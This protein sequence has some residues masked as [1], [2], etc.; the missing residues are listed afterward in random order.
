[1][2]CFFHVVSSKPFTGK[3]SEIECQA[4]VSCFS[5]PIKIDLQ[6]N[7]NNNNNKKQKQKKNP[8]NKKARQLNINHPKLV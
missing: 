3:P 5:L 6:K 7:K 2:G 1:M 4:P 8:K